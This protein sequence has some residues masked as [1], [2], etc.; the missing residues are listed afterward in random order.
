MAS[1]RAVA[2]ER[3]E[4]ADG[5][6]EAQAVARISATAPAA[7]VF[8]NPV[9]P[10]IDLARLNEAL[11]RSFGPGRFRVV[12]TQDSDE[13]D[14]L[15]DRAV[16]DAVADGCTLAIAAGGDGT[17]SEVAE[18]LW[19]L[20]RKA[21]AMGLAIVPCGTANILAKELGIPTDLDAAVAL[22]ADPPR[23]VPLDGL[24]CADHLILTQVG[25]GLD[26]YMIRDTGREAR[27]RFGRLSY[28]T[29]LARRAVGHQARL[30]EITTGGRTLRVRAWQI[31][32]A[33]A[34]TLGTKPF[35]WGP[36]V[37]PTD[38]VADV[39]IFEVRRRRH[40][41][42]LAWNVLTGR[43]EESRHTRFLPVR[44]D[45]TIDCREKMPV[46][47]DGEML[48]KT[49]VRV[50]VVPEAVR[51][52]VPPA[53]EEA[54]AVDAAPDRSEV[55]PQ[56]MRARATF[57]TR[58]MSVRDRLGAVDTGVY[59]ALNQ[60]NGGPVVDWVL[61]MS[62]RFLDWGEAWIV[63]SVIAALS[64]SSGSRM[65][66]AFVVPPL[67]LAMLT[68]NY[69][70]KMLF[71]RKRPFLTHERA[72]LIG[73]RPTDSSFPSGHTAAAFAGAVLLTPHLPGV[74]PGFWAYAAI[75]GFSR[76]YLGVH[77]PA[78]VVFGAAIGM[79]LAIGYGAVWALL[80]TWMGAA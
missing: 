7:V 52:V 51:V 27:N 68:V 19:R 65:V 58:V 21:A 74:A 30:F 12:E 55:S 5:G 39:C 2:P 42:D 4:A 10:N 8:A 54:P 59:L 9:A 20:G 45:V 67:W 57:R 37:D 44:D 25:V 33:N 63:V 18:S 22:A 48:G 32:V 26:A 77:F 34:A 60:L 64:A 70:I 1:Q 75:V 24:E 50:D 29:S 3:V 31:V 11:S 69:P 76:V 66:P 79:G 16:L 17:V 23:V 47:G 71:R 62:S 13:A 6:G 72:R 15:R 43:H 40:V 80:L 14:A 53:P 38:G 46:Q 36:D 78:D 35:T 28:L 61:R 73:R 56:T 49:P 41:F